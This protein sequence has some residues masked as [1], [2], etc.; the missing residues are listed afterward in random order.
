MV[1]LLVLFRKEIVKS[2]TKVLRDSGDYNS[3]TAIR[4]TS[5]KRSA[6]GLKM[7]HYSIHLRKKL[8]EV[9]EKAGW[10]ESQFSFFII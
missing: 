7:N 3:K 1:K 8:Q 4:E 9:M 6:E 5:R 2:L 10:K